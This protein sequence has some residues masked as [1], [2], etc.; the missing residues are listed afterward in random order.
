[1]PGRRAYEEGVGVCLLQFHGC[2]GVS[3]VG[4]KKSVTL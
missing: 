4:E 2:C 1:M 3:E